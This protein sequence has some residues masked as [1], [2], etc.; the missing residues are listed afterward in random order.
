MPAAAYICHLLL[1]RICCFGFNEWQVD[2]KSAA[3]SGLIGIR[4]AVHSNH[5]GVQRA[6][7]SKKS[8]HSLVATVLINHFFFSRSYH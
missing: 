2:I 8:G 5:A 1:L 6:S 7:G 3:L 4:L